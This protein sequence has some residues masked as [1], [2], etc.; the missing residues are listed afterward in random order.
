MYG[1]D[2]ARVLKASALKA[3]LTA[4]VDSFSRRIQLIGARPDEALS[5]PAD[6]RNTERGR[7]ISWKCGLALTAQFNPP[8]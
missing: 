2:D 8:N 3:A 7:R 4:T 1:S 5:A 6:N